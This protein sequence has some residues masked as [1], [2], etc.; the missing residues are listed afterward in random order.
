MVVEQEHQQQVMETGG[1]KQVAER[2]PTPHE[3]EHVIH[4]FI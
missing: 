2:Y 1:R 3:Q 4:P